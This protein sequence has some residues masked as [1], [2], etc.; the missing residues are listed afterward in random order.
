MIKVLPGQGKLVTVPDMKTK[1]R[2][3]G[4]KGRNNV[5]RELRYK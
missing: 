4:K 5:K 1:L 2:E 3:R